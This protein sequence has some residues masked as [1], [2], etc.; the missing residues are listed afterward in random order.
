MDIFRYYKISECDERGFPLDWERCRKCFGSGILD[1]PDQGHGG[2][3]TAINCDRCDGHGSLKAASLFEAGDQRQVHRHPG[4]TA[5]KPRSEWPG[6]P[7]RV[8]CE[9]CGHPMSEGTWEHV[10]VEGWERVKDDCPLIPLRDPMTGSRMGPGFAVHYSPCDEGCR[11]GG[12]FRCKREEGEPWTFAPHPERLAADRRLIEVFFRVEAS[13]RPVDV[14]TLDR[15]CMLEP[16][17]LAVLCL[18]CWVERGAPN[19]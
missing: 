5:Y 17:F 4:A 7:F 9:D 16:E 8:R 15:P 6:S 1:G 19:G 11:H 14:R 2:I 12:P 3:P 18:R 10:G 13:W